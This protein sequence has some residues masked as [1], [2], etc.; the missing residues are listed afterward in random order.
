MKSYERTC[1]RGMHGIWAYGPPLQARFEGWG[2]QGTRAEVRLVCSTNGMR[3]MLCFAGHQ[4]YIR[5]TY[6]GF[7]EVGR[8][9]MCALAGTFVRALLHECACGGELS[10]LFLICSSKRF[11]GCVGSRECCRAGFFGGR[12][13]VVTAKFRL[14]LC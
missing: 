2:Q 4:G 13:R 14:D 11:V 9:A 3:R 1:L 12:C 5:A 10:A 7:S 8:S 6:S